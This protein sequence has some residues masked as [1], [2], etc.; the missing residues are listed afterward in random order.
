M[1][2]LKSTGQVEAATSDWWHTVSRAEFEQ[3]HDFQSQRT[4]S[5]VAATLSKGEVERTG[6]GCSTI[7]NV[8]HYHGTTQQSQWKQQQSGD[9]G[10]G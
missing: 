5:R 1:S 2:R 6:D 9:A 3:S 8:Q 4:A 7:K 10:L